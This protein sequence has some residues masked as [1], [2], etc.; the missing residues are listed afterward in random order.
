MSIAPFTPG[1]WRV[2]EIIDCGN[3]WNGPIRKTAITGANGQRICEF[4]G[5]ISKANARV[6]ERATSMCSLLEQVRYY[7]SKLRFDEMDMQLTN[8]CWIDLVE[9][10]LGKVRGDEWRKGDIL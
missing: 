8:E 5:G 7:L 10:E 1:P 6:I 2:S 4:E 3:G 9:K